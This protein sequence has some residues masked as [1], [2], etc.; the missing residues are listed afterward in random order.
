MRTQYE[1]RGSTSPEREDRVAVA[2]GLLLMSCFRS[3]PD[4]ALTA[5]YRLCSSVSVV[6]YGLALRSSNEVVAMSRRNRDEFASHSLRIGG[7]TTLPAGRDISE[8]VIN[9]EGRW[10]SDRY[11]AFKR[12]SI[13]VDRWEQII[14]GVASGGKKIQLG[15]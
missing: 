4:H 12:N 13:E 14:P 6:R 2:L 3:L 10:M 7:A 9:R 8:R 5:S 15:G 11:M 1:L